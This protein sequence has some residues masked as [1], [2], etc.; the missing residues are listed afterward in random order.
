MPQSS[1]RKWKTWTDNFYRHLSDGENNITITNISPYMLARLEAALNFTE[2]LSLEQLEA[3]PETAVTLLEGSYSL[4]DAYL[5]EIEYNLQEADDEHDG[6]AYGLWQHDQKAVIEHMKQLEPL[7]SFT[8]FM[9]EGKD[10]L[11][12]VH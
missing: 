1:P 5:L 3:A 7:T 6:D 4:L 9:R 8:W 11:D 12:T 10:D 2:G